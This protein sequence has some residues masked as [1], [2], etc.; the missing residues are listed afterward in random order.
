MTI[1]RDFAGSANARHFAA[2]YIIFK[3]DDEIYVKN[4]ES[5]AIEYKSTT[6]D[7]VLNYILSKTDDGDSAVISLKND[8]YEMQN[9]VTIDKNIVFILYGNGSTINYTGDGG[10][11]TTIKYIFDVNV[12]TF[13]NSQIIKI[14]DLELNIQNNIDY[15][16]GFYL[17]FQRIVIENVWISIAYKNT[18]T[19]GFYVQN[20]GTGGFA[21]IR[22]ATVYAAVYGFKLYGGHVTMIQTYTGY[23]T[24][25][26]YLITAL[27]N[28]SLISTHAFSSSDTSYYI[29]CYYGT[30]LSAFNIM[31]E[32]A[33]NYDLRFQS[34]DGSGRNP[35]SRVEIYGIDL[36]L[37]D[38]LK[39]YFAAGTQEK[40]FMYGKGFENSGLSTATG[41][42]T[43]T[44]FTIP[45]G[46]AI[47]PSKVTVI[48]TTDAAA[49]NFYVT[50]DATNIYIN[51]LTAPPSSTTAN[52]GWLW[53]ARV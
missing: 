30:L 22:G 27:I 18:N 12:A 46:L 7:N 35:N 5:G 37:G 52:L 8:I 16:G 41:D 6:L 44:Q 2:D 36:G 39:L 13:D 23:C 11:S 19:Y 32:A 53:T 26:Y 4:G 3:K 24:Y 48:P 21:L 49:A 50:K 15:V 40:V 29:N 38:T 31:S 43:T 47:E 45:H 25:G 1:V 34:I 10:D 42:G 20:N 33:G 14:C 9:S 17:R 28:V 51:Y